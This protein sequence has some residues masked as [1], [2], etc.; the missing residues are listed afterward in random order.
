MTFN[1][2]T[3]CHVKDLYNLQWAN[4]IVIQ[5]FDVFSPVTINFK[6]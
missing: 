4:F 1:F 3:Y 6:E 2:T 5:E